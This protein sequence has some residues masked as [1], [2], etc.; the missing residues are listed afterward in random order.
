M[1][2]ASGRITAA[3][4]AA[5]SANSTS[6]TTNPTPSDTIHAT[7]AA[8]AMRPKFMAAPL[9]RDDGR[10]SRRS[11][12]CGLRSSVWIGARSPKTDLELV[13]SDRLE[14]R[15]LAREL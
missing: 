1:M 12:D 15:R 9:L 2:S 10:D 3:L 8:A 7:T 11:P 5:R 13:F 4:A 14:D 6:L